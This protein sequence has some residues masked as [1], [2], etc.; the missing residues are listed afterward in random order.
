MFDSSSIDP[1]IDPEHA[2]LNDD[3]DRQTLQCTLE[4][5]AVLRLLAHDVEDGVDE[6]GALGVVSLGPVVA[7]AGLSEDEVVGAE[8]G[9]DGSGAERVHG[10]G[11][12]VHEHGAGHVAAA[13]GLVVVDVDPLELL[14]LRG[15]RVVAG[16]VDAMLAADHLPELGPDLVAALA[17]LDVQDLPHL[18]LACSWGGW[19][20]VVAENVGYDGVGRI[21]RPARLYAQVWRERLP[22]LLCFLLPF[23]FPFLHGP[24]VCMFLSSLSTN[25]E[26]VDQVHTR[27]GP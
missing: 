25:D 26:F 17:A 14:R 24:G 2:W 12:E 7:G 6:L 9:A 8:D 13:G 10:A 27:S 19:F 21:G 18:A 3:V 23:L 5:V 4:A 15:A 16:G 1:E 22:P 20:L 11:L